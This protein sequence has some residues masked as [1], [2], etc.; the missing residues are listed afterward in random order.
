MHSTCVIISQPTNFQL[1]YQVVDSGVSIF[2]LWIVFDILAIWDA[3][4]CAHTY[5]T[6]CEMHGLQDRAFVRMSC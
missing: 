1:F 6:T 3:G 2:P 5:L 4:T